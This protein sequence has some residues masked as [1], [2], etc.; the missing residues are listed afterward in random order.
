MIEN[1]MKWVK[2]RFIKHQ[3]NLITLFRT[4]NKLKRVH[5][6]VI[7]LKHNIFAFE[8]LNIELLI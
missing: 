7:E 2:H 3:R 4:S 6:L 5:L 1:Y 8:R